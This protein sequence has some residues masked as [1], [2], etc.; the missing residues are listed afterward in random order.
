MFAR[1]YNIINSRQSYLSKPDIQPKKAVSTLLNL[2]EQKQPL[3]S[4][5][6]DSPTSDCLTSSSFITRPGSQAC[7]AYLC[8]GAARRMFPTL[9]ILFCLSA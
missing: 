2:P 9:C 3:P 4:S 7:A 1:E 8:C 5:I 6:S